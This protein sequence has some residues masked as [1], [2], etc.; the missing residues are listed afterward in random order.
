ML[1]SLGTT[2]TSEVVAGYIGYGCKK[3]QVGLE[4]LEGQVDKIEFEP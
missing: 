2:L 1:L 4:Q 3:E